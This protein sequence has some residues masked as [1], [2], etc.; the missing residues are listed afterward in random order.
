MAPKAKAA[1]RGARAASGP[2]PA[3]GTVSDVPIYSIGVN[4]DI[5]VKHLENVQKVLADPF[6]SNITSREPLG[7]NAGE[8][9]GHMAKFEAATAAN[10]LAGAGKHTCA[11]NVFWLDPSYTPIGQL[12][13][14]WPSIEDLIKFNFTEGGGG[15]LFRSP[16]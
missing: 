1:K 7:M 6:F 12:P 2:G 15:W 11:V 14:S 4:S 13:M 16:S 8:E 5:W 9:S 3:G 10:S